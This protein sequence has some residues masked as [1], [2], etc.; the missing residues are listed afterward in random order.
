[1]GRIF[2]CPSRLSVRNI[3]LIAA[4][5]PDSSLPMET[6]FQ[7]SLPRPARFRRR[8]LPQESAPLV[9][10]LF[11]AL[12]LASAGG[13]DGLP[14]ATPTAVGMSAAR[15]AKI[16]HVIERGITAGGYPGAAVVVGRRGSAVWEKGFGRLGW[17]AS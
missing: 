1:M 17:S 12:F 10:L 11:S 15:L 4:V 7:A 14:A 13:G 5:G 2:M 3:W 8:N 9:S 16:D 6:G